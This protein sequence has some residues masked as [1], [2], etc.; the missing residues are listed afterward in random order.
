MAAGPLRGH[1][2]DTLYIE[3]SDIKSVNQNSLRWMSSHIMSSTLMK[4]ESHKT[5]AQLLKVCSRAKSLQRQ[6]SDTA[7]DRSACEGLAIRKPNRQEPP[8]KTCRPDPNAL[9][10]G[11]HDHR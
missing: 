5:A 2:T 1:A 6:V 4:E 10:Y 9:S 7:P 8:L 11:V 3:C